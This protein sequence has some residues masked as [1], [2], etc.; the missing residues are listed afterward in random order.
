MKIKYMA[1]RM[2]DL[3]VTDIYTD[4]KKD[5]EEMI[6]ESGLPT[7]YQRVFFGYN[8]SW[9]ASYQD[10]VILGDGH[11]SKIFELVYNHPLNY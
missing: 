6:L 2:K 7:E 4:R 3:E 9:S 5:V 8:K 1:F 11:N 10:S